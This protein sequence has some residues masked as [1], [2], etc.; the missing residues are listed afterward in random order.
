MKSLLFIHSSANG[1]IYSVL[2]MCSSWIVKNASKNEF[3]QFL[4]NQTNE[5]LKEPSGFIEIMHN[6]IIGQVET[7][8]KIQKLLTYYYLC[9]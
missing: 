8:L 5:V 3:L 6:K 2:V 1:W 7:E 4:E 9:K